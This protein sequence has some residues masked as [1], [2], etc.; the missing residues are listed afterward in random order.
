MSTNLGGI[1]LT[2]DIVNGQM[3][4]MKM[5]T[6]LTNLRLRFLDAR[7]QSGNSVQEFT[8]SWGQHHFLRSI[9]LE[10]ARPSMSV[11]LAVADDFEFEFTVKP[12]LLEEIAPQKT[13]GHS[14]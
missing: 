13:G 5:P 9:D 4:A 1:P 2:I 8:G 10:K 6:N 11:S 14:K 12:Q 7:N 3:L